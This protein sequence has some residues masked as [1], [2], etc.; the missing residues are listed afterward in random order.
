M[1]FAIPSV[2]FPKMQ[3]KSLLYEMKLNEGHIHEKKWNILLIIHN[4]EVWQIVFSHM[5]SHMTS[6]L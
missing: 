4:F 2:L 3:N 6:Y 5:T 1:K